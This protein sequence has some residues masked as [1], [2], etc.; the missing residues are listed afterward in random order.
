MIVHED[1]DPPLCQIPVPGNVVA[2]AE[3]VSHR[4]LAEAISHDVATIKGPAKAL[5]RDTCRTA[6]LQQGTDLFI[7]FPVVLYGECIQD[8]LFRLNQ[9]FKIL[10]HGEKFL[11]GIDDIDEFIVP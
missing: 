10:I 3:A 11:S 8:F 5:E 1:R 9:L 4:P 6:D 7:V 2:D